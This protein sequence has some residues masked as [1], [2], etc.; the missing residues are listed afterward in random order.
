MIAYPKCNSERGIMRHLKH[1]NLTRTNYA[2]DLPAPRLEASTLE[3]VARA[4][5]ARMQDRRGVEVRDVE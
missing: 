5:E 1:W 2:S 4:Y 3:Y